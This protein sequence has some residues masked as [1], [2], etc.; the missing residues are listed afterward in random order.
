M[1]SIKV[2][3]TNVNIDEEEIEELLGIDIPEDTTVGLHIG[4]INL[5]GNGY[6]QAVAGFVATIP[7]FFLDYSVSELGGDLK[8]TYNAEDVEFFVEKN[9]TRLSLFADS[10]EGNCSVTFN[11]NLR[12][13]LEASIKAPDLLKMKGLG[14][15]FLSNPTTRAPSMIFC[16]NAYSRR[17]VTIPPDVASYRIFGSTAY[18]TQL[19]I[20][21]PIRG[22]SGCL[23]N[24]CSCSLSNSISSAAHTRRQ[25]RQLIHLSSFTTG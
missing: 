8:P 15:R 22:L 19:E 20:Q 23:A 21:C 9:G 16:F 4:S 11:T 13:K 10:I 14:L 3:G 12:S 2:E 25:R 5:D 7:G 24:T 1:S 17:A 6:I 18:P